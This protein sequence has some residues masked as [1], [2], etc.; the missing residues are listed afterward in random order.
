MPPTKKR[1]SIEISSN[2]TPD[3]RSKNLQKAREYKRI[4]VNF[5]KPP[6]SKGHKFNDDDKKNIMHIFYTLQTNE[7]FKSLQHLDLQELTSVLYGVTKNT[8]NKIVSDDGMHND[9]RKNRFIQTKHI[10]FQYKGIFDNEIKEGLKKGIIYSS[11]HFQEILQRDGI[12]LSRVTIRRR[13]WEWGLC[14]GTLVARDP[15]RKSLENLGKRQK[16]LNTLAT[17][18]ASGTRNRIYIDESFVNKNHSLSKGWYIKTEGNEIFKPT[19]QGARI[20]MIAAIARTQ[21]VGI[22]IQNT[23]Q[24]LSIERPDGTH[25]Y[26]AIKYWKVDKENENLGNVNYNIFK[27]YFENSVIPYLPSNSIIIIDNAKYHRCYPKNTIVPT[28]ACNKEQLIQFL[29]SFNQ[30]ASMDETKKKLLKRAKVFKEDI[31]TELQVI[32]K[33]YGHNLLYLPPYHPE[34]SPIEYAWGH[35]KRNVGEKASYN[36]QSICQEILPMAFSTLNANIIEKFFNHVKHYEEYYQAVTQEEIQLIKSQT[37]EVKD[38]DSDSD[39]ITDEY[40]YHSSDASVMS[41]F[42]DYDE[43]M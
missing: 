13:M 25:E 10:P 15:N 3:W 29:Q 36:I 37:G 12:S 19:G 16:F 11:R 43:E 22:R 24:C 39:S 21:W 6:Y 38:D 8:V 42:D 27:S 2:S 4:Q 26:K 7:N 32:A 1:K 20:A 30:I 9:G 40:S 5:I 17:L 35:I 33:A 23:R 28:S 34:I 31:Q 18:E 41:D 14:W